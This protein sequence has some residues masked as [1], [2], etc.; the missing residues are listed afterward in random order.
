[1]LNAKYPVE[2]PLPGGLVN[3]FQLSKVGLYKGRVGKGARLWKL[4][5]GDVLSTAALTTEAVEDISHA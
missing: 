5:Q 2:T 1:M 4:P 3:R